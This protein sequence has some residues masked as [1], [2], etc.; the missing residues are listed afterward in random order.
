MDDHAT[1]L[2]PDLFRLAFDL[3]PAGMLA[4]DVSGSILLVNREVERLFGYTREELVGAPVERLIP[5][6]FRA[7]HPGHRAMFFG[8]PETRPMG[9]GR[10]LFGL[11]KD[12]AEVPIEIGLNPVHS[13]TGMFVLASIVEISAR[14]RIE[15]QFRQSQKLEAIGTLAGGVA[16]DF[17]NILFSIMGYAELAQCHVPGDPRLQADLG[18]VLKAAER[19]RQ[20][21]QRILTFSRR[22]EVARAAIRLEAPIREALQLLRASLP[23]T[24]EMRST[25]DPDTPAVVSDETEIHQVVMNLATNSAHAMPEGGVLELRLGPFEP[26]EE[27]AKRHP[28]VR[29]GRYVRLT[30]KDSGGGMSE[31]VLR[32]AFEPFF[33]TKPPGTGTGLGLSVIHGIVRNHGGVIELHS[34]P[35]EGT[36]VDLYLPAADEPVRRD[37]GEGAPS[38]SAAPRRA[39]HLLV[40]EDEQDLATM[41]KRQIEE[42]GYR[43]TLHTSSVDALEDFRARPGDFQLLVTDNTMPRMTG[44]ALTEHILRARPDLPVL[45]ISGLAETAD[46]RALAARG[47]RRLLHKPHTWDDLSKAIREL[48]GG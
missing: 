37:E 25:L 2:G 12:G 48:L 22:R 11:R 38:A 43:V 15:E 46:P 27:F 14:R 44:L 28:E 17:N 35:G 1:H 41:L 18:Q 34:Q 29:P 8:A 30:V 45:L 7:A 20:L 13:G 39:A 21:V 36:R 19:G 40:V 10:D 3:S 32:R 23:A 9:A 26:G 6:R 5:E 42:L 16:H 31:E 47:I 4:L 33:T 24:I